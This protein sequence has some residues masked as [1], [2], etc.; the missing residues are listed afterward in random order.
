MENALTAYVTNL[1]QKFVAN[2]KIASKCTE[3]TPYLAFDCENDEEHSRRLYRP[4]L[5]N[6][7]PHY[8]QSSIKMQNDQ[9]PN[10]SVAGASM[11]QTLSRSNQTLQQIREASAELITTPESQLS[12][13]QMTPNAPPLPPDLQKSFTRSKQI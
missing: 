8:A 6:M 5:S 3:S 9:S 7:I 1:R 12:F 10:L 4:I 2:I 11:R 13:K